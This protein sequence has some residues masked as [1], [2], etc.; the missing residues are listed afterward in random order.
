[1]SPTLDECCYFVEAFHQKN[2]VSAPQRIG[3]FE[4]VDV[5]HALKRITTLLHNEAKA[6]QHMLANTEDKRALRAHLAA[7]EL[8][9]QFGAMADGDEEGVLD[10]LA[11]R[12]YILIGD[13][14]TFQLPI[15]EAFVEVHR[16]NM[17][18]QRQPNDE[19]GERVR[20]K[21]PDY[22]PPRLGEILDKWWANYGQ[23]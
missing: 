12:L 14:V 4:D 13:A 3:E 22:E 21:G 7:E 6:L 19:H 15:A 10:A 18:K 5:T 16:S 9:E 20:D 23:A 11:D 2:D 1:M 17:T 8:A